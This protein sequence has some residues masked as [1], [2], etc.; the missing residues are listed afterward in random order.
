MLLF[1]SLA[2]AES[3]NSSFNEGFALQRKGDLSG[4]VKLY[5]RAIEQNPSFAMAYE[6]RGATMQQLKKYPQ[7]ISDYS[8]VIACGENYFKAVGYYNR[9]VV[10][11]MTGAF[12]E[13]IF[14]FSQ[15]IELDRKMAAAYFHRGLAKSKT[16][17][18]SGRLEDFRQAAKLGD[19]TAEA[20]L[21][22]YVPDWR[23]AP[24]ASGPL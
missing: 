24:I 20:W 10:K 2:S 22:T 6:M 8:M 3:A 19:L 16:G 1:A 7:A 15:A 17:D 23:G 14:D 13:A 21:N 12:A 4:A 11:N 9:G 5:S 18:L